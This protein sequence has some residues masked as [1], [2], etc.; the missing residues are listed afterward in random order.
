MDITKVGISV[1]L[2]RGDS[3]LLGKR[4]GSHGEGEW[5]TP[6][7]KLEYMESFAEGATR[8]MAE[9]IGPQ[10]KFS[11]LQVFS[12]INL[13][14]YAPKHYIDIGM[15][16][17]WESGDAALMEPDKCEE[18]RWWDMFNLPSPRFATIDRLMDAYLLRGPSF[19]DV[20]EKIS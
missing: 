1:L 17:E 13:V 7:G 16:A 20:E 6:G 11:S 12:V 14:E 18:W 19:V 9:E 5:G 15:S 2:F 10:V 4:K 8:E 3:V